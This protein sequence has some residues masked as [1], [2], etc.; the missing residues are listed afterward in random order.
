[1]PPARTLNHC[2]MRE[3]EK[4]ER[5]PIFRSVSFHMNNMTSPVL[6][7]TNTKVCRGYD[8]P[9]RLCWR[10][11]GQ[12]NPFLPWYDIGTTYGIT[13]PYLPNQ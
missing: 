10:K 2:D 4:S 12:L 11:K 13:G 3:D 6:I 5:M 9:T 8:F 7:P 1:M